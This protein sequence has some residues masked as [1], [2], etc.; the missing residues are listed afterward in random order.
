MH[1]PIP[2]SVEVG[3]QGDVGTIIWM[4]ALVASYGAGSAGSGASAAIE[5]RLRYPACTEIP[6]DLVV[7][8]EDQVSGARHCGTAFGSPDGYRYRIELP[9]GQYRVFASAPSVRPGYRAYYSESV[10]CGLSTKCI[11]HSPIA[12]IAVAGRS[13]GGVEPADWFGPV[14]KEAPRTF[15][16]NP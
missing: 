6:A 10:R 14:E 8:A 2:A 16:S 13:R 7:C 12:V 15:A 9:A 11:D 4:A 3:G 1:G 5:G